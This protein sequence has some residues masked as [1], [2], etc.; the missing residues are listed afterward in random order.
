MNEETGD[1][2]ELYMII[3]YLGVKCVK[4]MVCRPFEGH[5]KC[6]NVCIQVSSYC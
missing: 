1:I 5:C 2:N 6:S 3:K 4:Y